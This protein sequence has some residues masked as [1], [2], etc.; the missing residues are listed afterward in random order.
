MD[1]CITMQYLLTI[2]RLVS[3]LPTSIRNSTI[4]HEENMSTIHKIN[5]TVEILN[6]ID[7]N[8]MNKLFLTLTSFKMS[9][10]IGILYTHNL[11]SQ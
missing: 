4:L 6:S 5:Q 1:T 2:N 11:E 9:H 3:M 10:V 8:K 7:K